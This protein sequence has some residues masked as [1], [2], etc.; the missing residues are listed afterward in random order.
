M[1]FGLSCNGD[2]LVFSPFIWI[3]VEVVI[4][5]PNHNTFVEFAFRWMG[6]NRAST[7]R[8]PGP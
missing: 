7:V 1:H 6:W 4:F 8:Q 5:S 3:W 2:F